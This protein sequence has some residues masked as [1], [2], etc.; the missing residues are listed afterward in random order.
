[1]TSGFA[2]GRQATLFMSRGSGNRC[3]RDERA[4]D[5]HETKGHEPEGPRSRV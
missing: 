1:V 3:S 2:M 5:G 4:R